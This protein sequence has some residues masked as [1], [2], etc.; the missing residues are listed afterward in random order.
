MVDIHGMRISGGIPLGI[1]LPESG[2]LSDRIRGDWQRNRTECPGNH[3][4]SRRK[5]AVLRENDG[6]FFLY[7]REIHAEFES[8]V[9]S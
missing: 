4:G 9:F 7:G 1:L 3:Y 5:P 2:S 8:S 6:C